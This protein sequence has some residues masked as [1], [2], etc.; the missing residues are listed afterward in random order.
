MLPS[1]CQSSFNGVNTSVF[2]FGIDHANHFRPNVFIRSVVGVCYF[3]SPFS[4]QLA[5]LDFDHTIGRGGSSTWW[6]EMEARLT[7]KTL[8][9]V[10]KFGLLSVL[11]RERG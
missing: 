6:M 11:D 2:T 5:F 9:W 7:A 1:C 4:T 8:G 3:L 10:S